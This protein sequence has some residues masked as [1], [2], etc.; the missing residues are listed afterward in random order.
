M[1]PP[2][3]SLADK[4]ASFNDHWNPRIVANYNGNEI[5]VA[6]LCGAFEWH[7]HAGTDE[8]F[9]VVRGTLRLEFR[10]G[11]RTLGPGELCVVPAKTEHRPVA[12]GECEIVLFDRAEEPN[13]GVNPGR[14]TRDVLETI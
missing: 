10:D 3:I 1:T 4:L 8:L 13:T 12:D 11:A 6:K 5:R 9:L 14:F 2:V 7:S